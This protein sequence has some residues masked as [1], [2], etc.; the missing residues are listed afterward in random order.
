MTIAFEGLHIEYYAWATSPGCGKDRTGRYHFITQT[1]ATGTVVMQGCNDTWSSPHDDRLRR[2][3]LERVGQIHRTTL[4]HGL[5]GSW[6]GCHR[7]R[8]AEEMG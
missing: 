7:A 3:G 2:A 4:M 8:R 5:G 1:Q 6:L